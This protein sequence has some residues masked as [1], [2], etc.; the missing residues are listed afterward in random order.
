MKTLRF[1]FALL[2]VLQGLIHGDVV[3]M[4]D[5]DHRAFVIV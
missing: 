2:A 3:L 5:E 1:A 4:R